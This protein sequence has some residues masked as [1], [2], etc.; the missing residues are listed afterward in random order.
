MFTDIYKERRKVY[1]LGVE[2]ERKKE[3]K[4]GGKDIEKCVNER[5]KKQGRKGEK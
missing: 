3:K 2:E 5:R 4:K 1:I